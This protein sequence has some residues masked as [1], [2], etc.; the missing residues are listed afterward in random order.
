MRAFWELT[1]PRIT[2]LILMSTAMGYWYGARQRWS[3]A[4]MAFTLLGTGLLASGTAVLN[5]WYE[6]EIDSRML[7]TRRR[8]LPE[9]R[10]SPTA[11][12]TYGL[13]L[14]LAG[15]L[16]LWIAVNPL[17][18]TLG[19]FTL[20]SYLLLYTPLKTR[21]TWCTTLGAI[22]GAMPPLIGYAAAAGRLTAEAW[23]LYAILFL[24]QF[25]HFLSIAW[26]YR[27]DYARGGIRMLPAVEA[28]GTR[29]ARQVLYSSL[30]L[31]PV[32]LLPGLIGASGWFYLAAAF[33]L[34]LSYA[35]TA[36][37]LRIER[38]RGA[39]RRVLLASVFYLP[40]LYGAAVLDA[41]VSRP[42]ARV[43]EATWSMMKWN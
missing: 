6:R 31:L 41:A 10:L 20:L 9:G 7:R 33:L 12:F 40:L 29:T 39:A 36:L 2:W 4:P 24:W 1:K 22:P 25:P 15:F 19:L 30:I 5:Q 42:L 13:I 35:G 27:E 43:A 17:A 18:A 34:G 28:D 26:M 16:A 38:T 8:P 14:S 32:S 11:A 3:W 21:S 37:K 23:V